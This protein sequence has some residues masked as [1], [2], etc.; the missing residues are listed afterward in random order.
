MRD[1]TNRSHIRQLKKKKKNED[2]TGREP[3]VLSTGR[4]TNMEEEEVQ[5]DW[6]WK[7][8][9]Q[10]QRWSLNSECQQQLF[11]SLDNMLLY[12]GSSFRPAHY[13]NKILIRICF[14]APPQMFL[15]NVLMGHRGLPVS[16]WRTSCTVDSVTF[17]GEQCVRQKWFYF[18][19]WCLLTPELKTN[20]C[21]LQSINKYQDY[22]DWRK[23]WSKLS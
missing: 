23:S 1:H 17:S 5:R 3:G 7:A 22:P 9:F 4:E 12:T 19:G 21:Q 10:V 11:Q 15:K 14:A 13:F 8:P 18:F 2:L 20:S 16:C 6:M